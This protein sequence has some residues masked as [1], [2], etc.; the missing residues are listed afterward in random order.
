MQRRG[1]QRRAWMLLPWLPLL[2]FAL[3][4]AQLQVPIGLVV[5]AHPEHIPLSSLEPAVGDEVIAGAQ[6]G[7]RDNDTTG[8]F[9]G[10]DFALSTLSLERGESAVDAFRSLHAKGIRL[11]LLDLPAED[12]LKVADLAEAKD[13]LLFNV[14]APDDPLRSRQCRPNLLHTIPSRAMVADALAQYLAWKRWTHWFLVTGPHP[15][16][17]AYAG[18]LR[19]AAK[20]FGG[21]IAEEK[22]WTFQP[23]A[24]R[25]DSGH[26]NEQQEVNAFT[27]VGDYDILLVADERDE[28]GEYLNYRTYRPRPVGGTQGLVATAWS[29]V[30]EQWGATQFQRRFHDKTGRW[31]TP[32]DYAAWLAVRSIGEGATRTGSADAQKLRDYLLSPEFKLGAFKGVPVTYRDWDGQLR[33]PLLIVSPRV[34]VSVSPQ[35]GFLHPVS[36]LD[37]LGYDRPEVS[38]GG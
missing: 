6:Q 22:A 37:T 25:T 3:W 5:E 23:G 24:R 36:N 21:K 15:E 10:Q 38:C 14:G 27:Q 17:K 28:F 26:F 20:R 13:S 33:Q 35:P 30:H 9:T 31:M 7:I 32:R 34:L 29:G 1:P 18:A 16:D 4:A 19:R 2:P 8:R 12:L 11:V